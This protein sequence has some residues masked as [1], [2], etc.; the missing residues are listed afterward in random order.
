MKDI[1]K[2]FSCYNVTEQMKK[3]IPKKVIERIVKRELS[4]GIACVIQD[5]MDELPINRETRT[6]KDCFVEEH[7]ISF[8]IISADELHRLQDIEHEHYRT[9]GN[10]LRG[11]I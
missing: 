2:L 10:A 6:T 8:Y 9:Y 4:R 1:E 3:N 11:V 5:N 7:R